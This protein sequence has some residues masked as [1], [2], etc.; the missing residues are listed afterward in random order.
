[1]AMGMRSTR[2]GARGEVGA[3]EGV[4]MLRASLKPCNYWHM[5][6]AAQAC[7]REESP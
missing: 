5:R 3:K 1:M 7:G 6:L 4:A 2:V